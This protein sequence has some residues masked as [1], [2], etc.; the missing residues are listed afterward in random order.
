MD[1]VVIHSPVCQ[2]RLV[3]TLLRCR[4][5]GMA[6][7][8]RPAVTMGSG[9]TATYA[10]CR[11]MLSIRAGPSAGL[12]LPDGPPPTPTTE[13]LQ[14]R[15]DPKQREDTGP[16]S[17]G[18]TARTA[19]LRDDSKPIGRSAKIKGY[20]QL[21]NSPATDRQRLTESAPWGDQQHYS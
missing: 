12:L 1:A 3:R 14:F 20:P 2:V 16:D 18:P 17:K 19:G 11:A 8:M 15:A 4:L 10:R 13:L 5:V 6:S 7:V 21:A 9:K